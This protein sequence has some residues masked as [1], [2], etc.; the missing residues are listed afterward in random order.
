MTNEDL[1]KLRSISDAATPGPWRY[2]GI[3]IVQLTDSGKGYPLDYYPDSKDV[4]IGK[5]STCGSTDVGIQRRDDAAFIAAARSAVPALIDEIELLREQ[6]DSI[7]TL[8]AENARLTKAVAEA[9]EFLEA[10][11]VATTTENAQLR[12]AFREAIDIFDA[13]WCPEHGHAPKLEQLARIDELRKLVQH[14]VACGAAELMTAAFDRAQARL[15]T[16]EQQLRDH[17]HLKRLYAESRDYVDTLTRE[18]DQLVEVARR[19]VEELDAIDARLTVITAAR[20][21]ACDIIDDPNGAGGGAE[22]EM[23]PY[24]R[25]AELR[26]VGSA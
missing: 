11:K 14:D 8:L 5:C 3:D 26:K 6:V 19:H 10:V 15:A 13:T 17:D 1:D 23:A 21:E 22:H 24:R 25:A 12:A 9:P 7:P 4:A 2:D 20:D 16:L 18:R